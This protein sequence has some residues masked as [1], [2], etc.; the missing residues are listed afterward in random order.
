MSFAPPSRSAN[1]PSRYS[2]KQAGAVIA[3]Y[4]QMYWLIPAATPSAG[5][6]SRETST[7]S[8]RTAPRSRTSAYRPRSWTEGPRLHWRIPVSTDGYLTDPHRLRMALAR[9]RRRAC[10]GGDGPVSG[11]DLRPLPAADQQPG[12]RRDRVRRERWRR[13]GLRLPRLSARDFPKQRD[14]FEHSLPARDV[15]V[16]RQR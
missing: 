7:R 11:P 13:H 12:R 5:D 16:R 3:D 1:A 2:A 10:R 15:P 6:A 9:A 14:P 4:G 8:A